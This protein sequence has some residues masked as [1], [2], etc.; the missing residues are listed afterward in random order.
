MYCFT[1]YQVTYQS[2]ICCVPPTFINAFHSFPSDS[3]LPLSVIT[4]FNEDCHSKMIN[5]FGEI[6]L[7]SHKTKHYR[8]L[9]HCQHVIGGE[10]VKH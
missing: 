5:V 10:R 9:H 6:I 3:F 8:Q 1:I 2:L 7:Y 4:E